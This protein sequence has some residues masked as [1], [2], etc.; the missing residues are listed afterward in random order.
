MKKLLLFAL[1]TTGLAAAGT[2][3][4]SFRLYEPALLGAMTLAP[5]EYQVSVVDQNAVVRN[6]KTECEVPVKVE[7]SDNK[8]GSTTV[9]L[10]HADGKMHIQ[11]IHVGG[12]KTRLVFAE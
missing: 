6:A 8:Y 1:A 4:Y 5:G 2:K 7:T 9:R 10:D 3:A 12:T 11:E